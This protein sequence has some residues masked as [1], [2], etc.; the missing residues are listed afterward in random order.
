MFIHYY[1]INSFTNVHI[2][3]GSKFCT[4]LC[5]RILTMKFSLIR[6]MQLEKNGLL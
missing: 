1:T 2:E 3:N 4:E 6:Y 5:L